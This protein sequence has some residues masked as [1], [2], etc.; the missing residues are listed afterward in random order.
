MNPLSSCHKTHED[1]VFVHTNSHQQ[2]MDLLL[3]KRKQLENSIS[4]H[5]DEIPTLNHEDVQSVQG[6]TKDDACTLYSGLLIRN[7]A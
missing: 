4:S 6:A 7:A 3:E 1:Y 2:F 5:Q